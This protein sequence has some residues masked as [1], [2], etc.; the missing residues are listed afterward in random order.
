[1]ASEKNVGDM[2]QLCRRRFLAGTQSSI[3]ALILGGSDRLSGDP[4]FTKL[5]KGAEAVSPYAQRIFTGRTSLAREHTDAELSAEFQANGTIE[6]SDPDTRGSPKMNLP[7]GG[8]PLV[9]LSRSP[10][11]FSLVDLN[12]MPLRTQITRHDCARLLTVRRCACA[13]SGNSDGAVAGLRKIR[14]QVDAHDFEDWGR[15]RRAFA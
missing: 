3:D 1:M 11:N 14:D 4:E 5:L 10:E 15:I 6:P 8:L 7:I 12:E 13:T 9:D 2:K